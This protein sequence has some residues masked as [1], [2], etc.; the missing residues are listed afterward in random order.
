MAQVMDTLDAVK[1]YYGEVLSSSA[2]LKTSACC[3]TE[4]LAPH[5]AALVRDIH[6]QVRERFYAISTERR[7]RHPA[8]V[9][10]VETA[11]DALF[12]PAA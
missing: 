5:L 10:V 12:S 2:D 1:T 9:S 11:R 8:V 6:P 7:L 3:A 4:A